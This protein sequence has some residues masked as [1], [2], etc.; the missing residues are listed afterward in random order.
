MTSKRARR[1]LRLPQG[2]HLVS[3]CSSGAISRTQYL[4]D[5]QAIQRHS[6]ANAFERCFKRYGLW[7]PL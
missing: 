4:G 6:A 2:N 1:N 7:V 3:D 5:G